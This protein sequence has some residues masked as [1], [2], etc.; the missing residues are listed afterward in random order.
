[1]EMTPSVLVMLRS[2]RARIVSVSVALLLAGFGS[3][4]SNGGVT[5][6]VLLRVPLAAGETVALTV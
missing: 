2:A 4:T 1:M 5:V 3:V 6:A